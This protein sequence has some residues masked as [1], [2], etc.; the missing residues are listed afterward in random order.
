MTAADAPGIVT[1]SEAQRGYLSISVLDGTFEPPL[2]RLGAA[3]LHASLDV[4]L[5]VEEARAVVA[6]LETV[7]EAVEAV[8]V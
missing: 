1:V 4:D 5:T 2:I 8:T 3:I 6:Q 7:I